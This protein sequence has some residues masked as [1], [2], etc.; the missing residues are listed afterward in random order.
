M[1]L[2]IDGYNL[3]HTKPSLIRSH[4]NQLQW[5][6]D[7]LIDRLSLYQKVK[8]CRVTV[9][10]DGWQSGWPVERTEVRKGIEIIYSRLGEKADE[11]IKRLIKEKGSGVIV[12]TTD[13]EIA[14]FADRMNTPVISSNQFRERMDR[15]VT[16]IKDPF[17]KGGEEERGIRKKGL[18]KRPSKREKRI[19]S[20][21][22]KL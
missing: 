18:S 2:I 9:I 19:Q 21:I 20:A 16:Q 10:F 14:R 4:P 22:K 7:D 11:V 6:R 12:I 15:S 5:E 3:I 1:H 17:K 13:R 8:S